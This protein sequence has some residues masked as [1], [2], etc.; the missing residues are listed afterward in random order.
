M[1]L[2]Q[3]IQVAS[4]GEGYIDPH[5]RRPTARTQQHQRSSPASHHHHDRGGCWCPP[6][7]QHRLT[8]TPTLTSPKFFS[9]SSRYIHC[10]IH[11]R[12]WRDE[13]GSL[14]LIILVVLILVGGLGGSYYGYRGGYYGPG[15]YGGVGLVVI[16][17]I[18]LLLFSGIGGWRGPW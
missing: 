15:M 4:V 11:M 5:R 17:L 8:P 2:W 3:C 7:K 1:L 18:V 10:D 16:L 9:N 6:F 14:V 13:F 12:W